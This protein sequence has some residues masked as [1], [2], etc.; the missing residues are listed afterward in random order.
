MSETVP[1]LSVTGELTTEEINRQDYYAWKNPRDEARRR[2]QDN[3]GLCGPEKLYAPERPLWENEKLTDADRQRVWVGAQII[4]MNK[5]KQIFSQAAALIATSHERAQF[6]DDFMCDYA[7]DPKQLGQ[8][9]EISPRNNPTPFTDID[10]SYHKGVLNAFAGEKIIHVRETL[11]SAAKTRSQK[12]F[13][14]V[15]NLITMDVQRL[16]ADD[17][18]RIESLGTSDLRYNEIIPLTSRTRQDMEL[19]FSGDSN[20]DIL[21]PYLNEFTKNQTT[22]MQSHLVMSAIN[23]WQYKPEGYAEYSKLR[24]IEHLARERGVLWALA[25]ARGLSVSDRGALI[26]PIVQ[27]EIVQ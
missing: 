18:P 20:D 2:V 12:L 13:I 17:K 27:S 8:F 19:H 5:K 25:Q 11:D 6:Y 1:Q 24:P 3:Y 7:G 21:R 10:F 26:H 23:G 16:Y 14:V 4:E 22:A 9:R 15:A